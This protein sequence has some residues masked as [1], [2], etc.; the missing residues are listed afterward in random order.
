MIYL[1]KNQKLPNLTGLPLGLREGIWREGELLVLYMGL[2][3]CSELGLAGE[4]QLAVRAGVGMGL[5]VAS[6]GPLPAAP[7]VTSGTGKLFTATGVRVCAE[8][9][10][11]VDPS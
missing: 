1:Q 8:V 2:E 4:T 5:E 6:E 7:I 11:E 10:F 9:I 3:V